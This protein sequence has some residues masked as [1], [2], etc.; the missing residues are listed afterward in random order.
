[1][2][3][4]SNTNNTVERIT[5]NIKILLKDDYKLTFSW[6]IIAEHS[7]LSKIND[8]RL[9][10]IRNMKVPYSFGGKFV[11]LYGQVTLATKEG[12]NHIFLHKGKNNTTIC[13]STKID[14]NL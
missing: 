10:R 5:Y 9:L 8:S 11:N 13:R 7:M 4:N 12:P 2:S 3:E 14:V 1:M 6:C